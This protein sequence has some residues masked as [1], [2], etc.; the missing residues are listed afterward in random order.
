MAFWLGGLWVHWLDRADSIQGCF[1]VGRFDGRNEVDTGIQSGLINHVCDSSDLADDIIHYAFVFDA[2][3][4]MNRD[5]GAPPLG[6]NQRRDSVAQSYN[7]DRN[8][9]TNPEPQG[10]IRVCRPSREVN[11]QA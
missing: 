6:P 3:W 4:Q 11:E 9:T 8:P 2:G 1:Q 5:I 7:A 10:S